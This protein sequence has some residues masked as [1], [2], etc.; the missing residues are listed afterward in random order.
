MKKYI[1]LSLILVNLLL[2]S[3]AQKNKIEYGFQSG[4]NIN[5]AYGNGI[6]KTVN[7]ALTGL[8]IGGHFKIQKTKHFGL[9]AILAYDQNGWAYRS[10]TFVDNNGTGLA[11]GDLLSKLNY[12]NLPLLA[13]YSF[14]DKIKFNLDAGVFV[15]YLLSNK[16]IRKIKEPVAST[17]KTSSSF[18]KSANLGVS[19]GGG[20]QIPVSAKIKLDLGIQNNLGLLNIYKSATT[21]TSTIK[22]N[23][24]SVLCGITFNLK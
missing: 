15:G 13:E 12:I 22:T 1:S 6:S 10:L 2:I 17:Q 19:V 9:K 8:H 23:A 11:T 5:S 14:G 16:M 3:K 24:F 18:R 4:V 20:V 21:N 7:G